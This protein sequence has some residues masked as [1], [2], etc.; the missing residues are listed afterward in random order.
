MQVYLNLVVLLNFL[1]NLFLLMGTNRLSGFPLS[2]RRCILASAVGG[3]YAGACLLTAFRFLSSIL[4]RFICL[5]SMG[6]IAFGLGRSALRRSV[7][8]VLLCM[9]IGGV[10]L[11]VGN[12]SFLT[13]FLSAVIVFLLCA[14][15]F[16]G[17]IAGREYVQIEL[18]YKGRQEKILALHDTGNTLRD[19]VTGQSV[20]V[21]GADVAASLIGL[22]SQQLSSPV[23]TV[24]SGVIPGLR[25]I[26]YRTV[27]HES[28]ML[29]ALRMQQV[30]IGN[31]CGSSMV[32]FAPTGLDSEGTYQALTGGII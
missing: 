22:T 4:W 13:L 18:F 29:A 3:I 30:R 25:L 28:G 31:W 1:V 11:G 14:I 5:A 16:R 9:A 32:A 15:G 7:L 17:N 24:A 2:L 8:F 12:N 6:A 23:E 27:G 26:P 21:V 10:S 19:P 20:I